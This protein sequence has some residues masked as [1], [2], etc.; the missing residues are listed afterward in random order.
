MLFLCYLTQL[1]DEDHNY[2]FDLITQFQAALRI[3]LRE[4]DGLLMPQAGDARAA[5]LSFR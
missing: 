4:I 5:L 3:Q 1:R 2:I